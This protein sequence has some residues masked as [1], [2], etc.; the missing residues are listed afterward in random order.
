MPNAADHR[1]TF[2]KALR[3]VADVIKQEFAIRPII[4]LTPAAH[5]SGWG[6]SGLTKKANNLFGFT[7]ESWERNGKPVIRLPTIEYIEGERRVVTRP[8]RAYNSWEESVRDW[9]RLM[10]FPRYRQALIW[11]KEG[12]VGAFAADVAAAGYATDPLYAIKLSSTAAAVRAL[13]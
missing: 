11:A 9:A 8:F 2:V 3:P 1:L 7:G 5:E 10:H 12:D 13:L 4:T 6:R